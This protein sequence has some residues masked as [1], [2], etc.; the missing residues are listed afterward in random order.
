MPRRQP[1]KPRPREKG[2]PKG[3]DSMFEYD[4][5]KGILKDWEPHPE[6]VIEYTIPKKYNTDFRKEIA[7][8]VILLEA[9]GR[10]W[11]TDEYAKYRH[12]RDCL[13]PN[14]EIVF[15]FMNPDY[16][17]PRAR[18]RKDGTKLTHGEWAT[19][20]GFRYYTVDTFP[21]ELM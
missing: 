21:K 18:P 5:H 19:R 7:G 9:K 17:M 16:P 12:C 6:E 20:N 11:D 8:R 3:F 15:L 4:L 13:P 2:V 10:F 1:R 14:Y